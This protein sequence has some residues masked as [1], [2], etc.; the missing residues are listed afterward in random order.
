MLVIFNRCQG[1]MV[2][3]LQI[4]SSLSEIHAEMFTDKMILSPK[5]VSNIADMSE[6]GQAPDW[7]LSVYRALYVPFSSVWTVC[8][9]ALPFSYGHTKV[10]TAGAEGKDFDYSFD[11]H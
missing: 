2:T 8:H 11:A 4:S 3:F 6:A 5:S 7:C 10:C 1:F 9:Y